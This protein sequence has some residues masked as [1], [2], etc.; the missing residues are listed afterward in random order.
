MSI[1]VDN[2][3]QVAVSVHE[4]DM[5]GSKAFGLEL[6]VGLWSMEESTSDGAGARPSKQEEHLSLP[7]VEVEH[8]A[9]GRKS[10]NEHAHGGLGNVK[11][12]RCMVVV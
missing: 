3:A 2:I 8:E 4:S 1:G 6:N 11:K 5:K 7:L 10:F 12:I 9:M